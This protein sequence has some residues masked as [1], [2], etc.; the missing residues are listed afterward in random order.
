M[1][2]L[3]NL[4]INYMNNNMDAKS[5]MENMF[6]LLSL[7]N[8][9]Q[10]SRRILLHNRKIRSGRIYNLALFIED[11]QIYINSDKFTTKSNISTNNIKDGSVTLGT[12][13]EMIYNLYEM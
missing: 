5:Y 12:F 1:N 8:S 9:R 4:S 3:K 13:A 10:A 6:N 7:F 11:K 2:I